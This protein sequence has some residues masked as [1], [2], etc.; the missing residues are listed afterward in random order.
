M[1]EFEGRACLVTGAAG[2]VG[3]AVVGR[4][5][6]RQ[7]KVAALCHRATAVRASLVL[8]AELTDENAV[9]A[10]FRQAEEALGPLWGVLHVAGAWR[11]GSPVAE[12]ELE[13]FDDLLSRNLRSAFLV[14]RCAMKR[15]RP[16][17]GRIVL[18]GARTAATNTRLSNAA[19]YNVSK[20]GVI[21]LAR[22][23]AEE[24]EAAG[25][26]TNCVAPGTIATEAN[27]AAMPEVGPDQW[28]SVE[29]V[30]ETIIAAA[31]PA[32]VLNGTVLTLRG[33]G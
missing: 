24:G 8:Q 3:K 25:V 26:F 27:K 28:V 22:A 20:A 33:R 16:R 5:L 1:T 23:L 6:E 21:A 19:A 2:S 14:S 12:T 13:L 10:A 29:E 17:G 4:L 30:A 15:L 18:V 9:E 32:C 7:A 31:S 11:G